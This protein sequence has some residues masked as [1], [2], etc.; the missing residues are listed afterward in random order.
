MNSKVLT[1]SDI[2]RNLVRPTLADNLDNWDNFAGSGD[3]KEDYKGPQTPAS[4]TACA[5]YCAADPECIQYRLTA[6][7][8]C[9]TSK[10]ILRGKPQPGIRSGTML[11]RV[12]AAM[13]QMEECEKVT[14]VTQ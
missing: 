2:F 4:F 12:D 7:S 6:D 8:R 3:D 5:D 1:Y 13:K 10:A 9:M 11:W 14:W